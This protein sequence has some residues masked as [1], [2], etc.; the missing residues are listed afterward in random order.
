MAETVTFKSIAVGERF[1][2]RG[3]ERE[4]IIKT[5]PPLVANAKGVT[6]KKPKMY[7]FLDSEKVERV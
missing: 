6:G 7:C 3:I 2:F 1:V 5:R 4:K